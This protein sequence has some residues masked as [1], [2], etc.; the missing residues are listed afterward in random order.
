MKAITRL[1]D[2]HSGRIANLFHCP[3]LCF[4]IFVLLFYTIVV[5]QV[6]SVWNINQESEAVDQLSPIERSQISLRASTC[7]VCDLHKLRIKTCSQVVHFN[8]AD[9]GFFLWAKFKIIKKKRLRIECRVCRSKLYVEWS[10]YI[11]LIEDRIRR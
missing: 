9:W 4:Y 3:Y 7:F 11:S 5:P 10:W 6:T 8:T 1:K 2:R